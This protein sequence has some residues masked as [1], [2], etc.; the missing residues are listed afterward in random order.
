MR[1]ISILSAV[2][3]TFITIFLVNRTV[4]ATATLKVWLKFDETVAGTT[5]EDSSG[6]GFNATPNG[7]PSPSTDVPTVLF[8]DPRSVSFNGSSDYFQIS[9]PV[10]DDMSI[11]AWIKTSTAGANTPHYQLAPILE[12]EVAFLGNDFGFGV[13]SDKKLAFGNGGTSDITIH[14]TAIVA[15]GNWNHVC[16]TRN[17]TTGEVLLYIN[18][19]QDGNGFTSTNTL[20]GNSNAYIGAGTDGASFFNGNIDD[21]RVYTSVLSPTEISALATGSNDP[22]PSVTPTP[23]ASAPVSQ[24][25]GPSATPDPNPPC[26]KETPQNSP[27]L[28]QIS[29]SLTEATLYFVPVNPINGYIVSYG[30]NENAD[31]YAVTFDYSNGNGAVSYTINSLARNTPYYFKVRGKNGCMPGSWSQTVKGKT[32]GGQSLIANS[33]SNITLVPEPTSTPKPKPTQKPTS[34]PTTMPSL[35]PPTSA[36]KAKIDG[37][38]LAIT[39]KHD[40]QPVPNATVELHSTP[41]RTVTDKEGIARFTNVE[42]GQHTVMIAYESYS[43]KQSIA[44]NGDKKEVAMNIML[45][46]QPNSTNY[47]AVIVGLILI[48]AI[49]VVYL[50]KRRQKHREA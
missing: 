4:W 18:G 6:N 15:N 21:L 46:M 50:I 17:Q 39:V 5:A 45:Q 49:L 3:F 44:V 29:T 13:D 35:V 30:E 36:P 1:K 7:P 9:R 26:T 12:S 40:G 27:D 23:S 33:E 38:D 8:N 43:G 2:F 48:I 19:T 16:A 22:N 10:Q 25:M 34:Q 31:Q 20:N 42:K 28:F 11:C 32:T 47:I 37:Y 41:R 24:P 14:S